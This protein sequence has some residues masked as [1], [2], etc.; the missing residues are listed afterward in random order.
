MSFQKI[1]G[2]AL[3]LTGAVFGIVILAGALKDRRLFREEK[4]R[5]GALCLAEAAV[6][7]LATMGFSD[8]LPN[9]LLYRHFRLD[10]DRKLPGTLIA[11]AL[12]PGSVIAFSLLQADD[13]VSLKV[14]VPC[15]I[16]IALGAAAGSRLV[17]RLEGARLRRFMGWALVASM[18][19]L[20]V[21]IVISRGTPGTL[22][23]LSGIRL[24]LAVVF[25]FF[26][27]GVNMLGVPMKAAGTAMFLLLGM[28]PLTALTL[29]LVL[30]C[31][32]PFSGAV[33]ILKEGRYHRRMACA[34]VLGGSLGA[35][36]GSMAALSVSAAALNIILL[37]VM[38]AAAVSVF[39]E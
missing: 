18:A 20:V 29:V 13:P 7:F 25:A 5:P 23:G 11:S 19:V 12:T 34:G 35:V 10:E 21:R 22:T 32:G 24:V 39:R 16:S 15:G 6:Y 3:L 31:I 2:T 30:G 17:G 33:P 9:T 28:S 1:I 38:L 14:L 37:A 26:W 8:M 4:G 27:G 36:L